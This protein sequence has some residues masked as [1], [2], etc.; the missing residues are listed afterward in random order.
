MWGGGG[1]G[2]WWTEYANMPKNIACLP[3][4]E[5]MQQNPA[6]CPKKLIISLLDAN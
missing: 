3:A 4:Y 1:G 2:G 5:F 6:H